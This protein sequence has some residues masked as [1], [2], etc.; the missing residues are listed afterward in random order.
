MRRLSGGDLATLAPHRKRVL[1]TARGLV[2]GLS[3]KGAIRVC[4]EWHGIKQVFGM[5]YGV[6]FRAA[7]SFSLNFNEMALNAASFGTGH[8]KISGP[9]T[10]NDELPMHGRPSR[11]RYCRDLASRRV[12]PCFRAPFPGTGMICPSQ[13]R[14]KQEFWHF[15]RAACR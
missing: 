4:P 1:A 14:L 11:G 15:H 8:L 5:S 9:P 7:S 3:L 12:A 2:F 10:L 6:E 13:K